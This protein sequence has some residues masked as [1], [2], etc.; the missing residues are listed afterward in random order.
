VIRYRGQQLFASRMRAT[1][2][3]AGP[4]LPIIWTRAQAARTWTIGLRTGD[5]R[6]D[7]QRAVRVEGAV[8][9]GASLGHCQGIDRIGH[10]K[11]RRSNPN[12]NIFVNNFW[13]VIRRLANRGTQGCH[14]IER[15]AGPGHTTPRLAQD[16]TRISTHPEWGN[17]L[18]FA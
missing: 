15:L 6:S 14:W 8:R 5:T 2:L 3:R 18:Y 1:T 10:T 17:Y 4:K 12:P 13:G 9:G 16:L 11:T 7:Y